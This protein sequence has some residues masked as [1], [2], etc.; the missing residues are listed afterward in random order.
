MRGKAFTRLW[1]VPAA[2]LAGGGLLRGAPALP[3]RTEADATLA[4][5][6]VTFPFAV[7]LA[8]TPFCVAL[9]VAA[10]A[11]LAR[12][13]GH[14]RAFCAALAVALMLSLLF[15]TGAA[16]HADTDNYLGPQVRLLALPAGLAPDGAYSAA[17][18]RLPQGFA[19]YGA[20]LYR[21]T[22]SMD[23]ASSA[24]WFCLFAAWLALRPSLTRLQ[25]LL[26]LACPGSYP[27]LFNLMPDGC[28]YL[29]LLTALAALR[30]RRFWL[31]LLAA[32]VACTFK[33]SAW[34]A[35]ALVAAVLLF[36]A[37]RRWWQ[38][39]LVG[40]ATL[41][42]CW[43]TLHLVLTGGLET[44]SEDFFF[45]ANED[46]KRLGYFGHLLYV[47]VGH[48]TTALHPV[49]GTHR[50]GV[51]GLSSDAL[52]PVFRLA[53]GASCLLAALCWRRL[54][55]WR[56]VWLLSMAT[57]FLLPPLYLGYARYVPLLYVAGFLPLIL[58]MPRLAVPPAAALAAIPAAYFGWRLA[59]STEVVCVANHAT[60]VSSHMYNIRSAFRPLLVEATQPVSSGSLLYS[61]AME[62][63]WFPPMPRAY[64]E[65]I[66]KK[67]SL[68]KMDEVA[69]YMA[70]TWAP[71]LLTHP[72]TYLCEVARFRACAF[73]N[74][75]RG[76]DDG[77]PA[78]ETR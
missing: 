8:Q 28:V 24:F 39:A 18:C 69:D 55:G 27:G 33:T 72:H 19:A 52:G 45:W 58:L 10:Y 5:L 46:S 67:D 34:T 63:E 25:T 41:L 50:G 9:A 53:L 26:L 68:D 11:L 57:L 71:W 76:A 31:P 65:G 54:K 49:V 35:T 6:L 62:P 40:A 21:L 44:I 22:G 47:Y 20:A 4:L 74:F 56:T 66:R 73:M 16:T 23:L 59:L 12:R 78:A 48:W 64:Y 43:P 37:P 32:A 75:P 7:A 17:H 77:L 15:F 3:E 14:L 70:R 1:S 38:I 51:D 61:Y 29:L 42:Y 13:A 36:R 2:W 30:E 60:A